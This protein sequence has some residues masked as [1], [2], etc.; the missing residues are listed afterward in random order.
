MLLVVVA[1][2]A[3]SQA[4]DGRLWKKMNK[5]SGVDAWREHNRTALGRLEQIDAWLAGGAAPD[6]WRVRGPRD[7]AGE[8]V[9]LATSVQK[10]VN[11]SSVVR[12]RDGRRV[13]V[14]VKAL[15]KARQFAFGHRE[16][17]IAYFELLWRESASRRPRR[18]SRDRSMNITDACRRLEYLRGEPGVPALYGGWMTSEHLVWV[19]SHGGPL[20]G[21]IRDPRVNHNRKKPPSMLSAY[22]EMARED[23]LHLARSWLRCFRSFAERGGFV[24]TDF[25]VDQFTLGRDGEIYLVDGPA[26][27]SGPVAAF[28]RRHFTSG[29]PD[30]ILTKDNRDATKPKHIDLEPGAAASCGEDRK[31]SATCGKRTYDYHRCDS[32]KDGVTLLGIPNSRSAPELTR[33]RDDKCEAFDWRVHVFDVARRAWI[34]PRIIALAKDKRA[35]ETL[36]NVADRMAAARPEDR[37]TFDALLRELA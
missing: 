30:N 27:N 18:T 21:T 15:R 8:G 6:A 14:V 20:I 35:R 3:T 5:K 17:D 29:A 32:C 25:K 28:A 36:A 2:V 9:A 33:C 4:T 22:D 26:P 19:V 34:L 13:P 12:E 31:R 10:E 37:P 23:P 24:L 11:A 1:V 7:L 16:S